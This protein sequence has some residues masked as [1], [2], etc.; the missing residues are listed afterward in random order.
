MKNQLIGKVKWII[1]VINWKEDQN[2]SKFQKYSHKQ[3]F[4]IVGDIQS[5][6]VT[7]GMVANDF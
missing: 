7:L 1:I 6:I 5:H 4:I 3:P 2:P